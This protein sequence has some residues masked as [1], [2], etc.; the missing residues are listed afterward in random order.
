MRR[1]S[2]VI[3]RRFFRSSRICYEPAGL[4]SF[5]NLACLLPVLVVH[6]EVF[7][8]SF[9]TSTLKPGTLLKVWCMLPHT[10]AGASTETHVR[11]ALAQTHPQSH[12]RKEVN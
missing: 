10:Q 4:R 5:R 2:A 12:R 11:L 8:V 6:T 3:Y 1:V 9:T 7:S